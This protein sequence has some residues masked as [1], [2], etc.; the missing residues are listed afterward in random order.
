MNQPLD[1]V[2]E[3]CRFGGYV[4]VKNL[5][6]VSKGFRLV[7]DCEQM[8]RQ[9]C[10]D[11]W[12]VSPEIERIKFSSAGVPNELPH[13]HISAKNASR[14]QA[15]ASDTPFLTYRQHYMNNPCVPMDTASILSAVKLCIDGGIVT[16][17]GGDYMEKAT[18]D[19]GSKNCTVVGIGEYPEL[20]KVT[21]TTLHSNAPLFKIGGGNR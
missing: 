13:T 11:T 20:P 16:V 4:L 3:V 15:Q 18:I 5:F 1:T 8:W 2:I 9:L 19:F 10:L 6:L 14:K 12:K 21:Y 7:L 17:F